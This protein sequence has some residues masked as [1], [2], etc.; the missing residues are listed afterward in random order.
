MSKT[1]GHLVCLVAWAFGDICLTGCTGDG[2]TD[3]TVAINNAISSGNR[4]SPGSCQSSTTTPAIVYFP[5]GTY[6]ISSS[7]IDF[8]ETQLIGNPNCLPTLKAASD[9][10]LPPGSLGVIDGDPYQGGPNLG[11][12]STNIFYRQVRNLVIDMTSFPANQDIR[13]IHWPTAQATSLQNVVF[14]MSDAPGTQH[15]GCFIENGKQ[16]PTVSEKTLRS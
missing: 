6:L 13:G 2:V 16:N 8:Y 5:A 3:D 7:I 9:F 15:Q 14:E 4:C 10:T 1:T 12:G 11:Y